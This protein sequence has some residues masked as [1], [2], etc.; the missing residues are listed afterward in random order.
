MTGFDGEYL[1]PLAA[2]AGQER[3]KLALLLL[4]V[5]PGLGGVLLVG[6]KGTAKSTAVRG[7]AEILP[8]LTV[9]PGC[10]YNCPPGR[11]AGLCP[12]CRRKALTGGLDSRTAPRPFLTLPLGAT[13]DRVAGGLDL[14]RSAAAGRPVLYPGLLGLANR[15]YL[16]V[17]EVNLL[18]PCLAHLLLDAAESGRLIVEREGLSLWHPARAALIGTMNPEEGRLGPQLADR[19]ALRVRV[20]SEPDP[21]VRAGIVRR[22]LAFEA[23]PAGFRREWAGRTAALARRVAEA[24][25]RLSHTRLSGAAGRL[26]SSY[27]KKFQPQGHRADLALARAA[28]ALAAWEGLAAAGAREVGRVAGLV[29][30][31]RRRPEPARRVKAGPVSVQA[32]PPS[33]HFEK[34][35][36]L[37]AREVDVFRG[38][39]AEAGDGPEAERL[40]RAN[41]GFEIVTPASRR[42]RGP[43]GR[44]GRRTAR[45]G[46]QARGRY[47]RSSPERLGRP[48]A[49]DA[50]L[51]AAAPHQPSRRRTSGAQAAP[52]PDR[53]SRD[54]AFLIRE[55]DLREK[56]FR[57]KTGRLVLFVVDAS[58]S[59][60]SLERMSEAKAAALSLLGEAY[61]K[62]DRVGLIAFHGRGAQVLLAPTGSIETA[63]RLL[64]DLPTGGKTPLAAAL[65][66]THRLVRIELARDP[67]LTPL[68]VL[69]TDG[70]PNVPL[71]PGEDPWREALHLAGL[72]ARDRRLRF[73]LVDTDRGHYSDYKLTRD[74][75]E[76]LG[77]P[78]LTLEDL[79][80]GRLE[81]WLDKV[82]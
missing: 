37:E 15:G 78:R 31:G 41:A 63:G 24:R 35:C 30:D 1:Y 43:Q 59:V 16:Y 56:V 75:A 4:A 58:G 49:V 64:A 17:D 53:P 80:Q 65:V 54:Q 70:R 26:M 48:L 66:D 77:A 57:H 23:D 9:V 74:L 21:V 12:D 46:R 34:P 52:G 22:R 20:E 82:A 10:P 13:E 55:P 19:F 42:E 69:L 44:T 51:R 67:D 50:T 28:R 39:A 71:D 3:M 38:P 76:R 27:I 40:Y 29:L 81:A 33:R 7:L 18:E 36:L 5:D 79:R 72:I 14:E 47:F 32:P 60:G 2:L 11:P 62:R 45:S 8:P 25:G 61:R 6:E 73:V 68:I